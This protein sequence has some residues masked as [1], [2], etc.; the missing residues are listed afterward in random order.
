MRHRSAS[1]KAWFALAPILW[2]AFVLFVQPRVGE[3]GSIA[4]AAAPVAAERTATIIT[5]CTSESR[6]IAV[7]ATV[8]E[9]HVALHTICVN[10]SSGQSTV[11][12]RSELLNFTS[13]PAVLQS[14]YSPEMTTLQMSV[15]LNATGQ[16][17]EIRR[18]DGGRCATVA[19]TGRG[20][21]PVPRRFVSESDD[22]KS[23]IDYMADPK[24]RV[25][26]VHL[27]NRLAVLPIARPTNF[28]LY[29]VHFVAS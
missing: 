12:E 14:L 13:D 19:A 2:L 18:N 25:L 28:D 8:S 4:V 16:L 15:M 5:L 7:D 21:F 26:A 9:N 10:D 27:G 3:H 24:C 22:W 6:L 20:R 23:S 29:E 17:V 11:S 1:R